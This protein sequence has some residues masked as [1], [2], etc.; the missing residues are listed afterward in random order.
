NNVV[1]LHSYP[2]PEGL[3]LPNLVNAALYVFSKEALRPFLNHR[4][5]RAT[6]D[7]CK[8]LFPAMM[9]QGG[10][11]HGYRSREYIKDAGTPERLE[12]VRRDY[13][14][15]RVAAGSLET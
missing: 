14:S 10:L 2:H 7:V 1:A 13:E 12:K 9:A 8:H 3:S 5:E 4:F 15:G 6:P 11:L